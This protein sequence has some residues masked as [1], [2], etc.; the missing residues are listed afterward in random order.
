MLTS[1]ELTVI[2]CRIIIRLYFGWHSVSF[3]DLA[4]VLIDL[5]FQKT[6]FSLN[7]DG[8]ADVLLFEHTG[9]TSLNIQSTN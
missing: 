9:L 1:P 6:N 8:D 4:Q 2:G 7:A 3:D 5:M